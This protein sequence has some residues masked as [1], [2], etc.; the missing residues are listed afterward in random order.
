MGTSWTPNVLTLD[1]VFEQTVDS[2]YGFLIYRCGNE[3]VAEDLVAETYLAASSK[4]ADGK[5]EEITTSWLLSV[6]RRR[7]IDY[8][9]R[10]SSRTRGLGLLVNSMRSSGPGSGS[11]WADDAPDEA[12][13]TLIL[14]SLSQRYRA[15]LVL[16]YLEDFAVSEVADALGLTY[17]ATESVLTRARVAFAKAYE[18]YR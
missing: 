2:V 9:R 7:L 13:I 15:A 18:E 17:K 11:E 3:S 4:F 1:E 10:D 16:R 5:G 12:D 14:A 8:W 6:A